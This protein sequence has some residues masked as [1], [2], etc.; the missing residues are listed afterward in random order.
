MNKS[1]ALDLTT[2]WKR[3]SRNT[4]YMEENMV[5]KDKREC[6]LL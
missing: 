5:K 2:R 4:F 3:I 1:N 6:I